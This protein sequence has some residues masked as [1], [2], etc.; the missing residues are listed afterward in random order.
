MEDPF[1]GAGQEEE[2]AAPISEEDL[3]TGP[4]HNLDDSQYKP[5]YIDSN[6]DEIFK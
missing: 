6:L 1:P 4:A 2:S 3:L 5:D